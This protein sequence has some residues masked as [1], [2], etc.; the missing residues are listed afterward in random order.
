[1]FSFTSIFDYQEALKE[2]SLSCRDTVLYYIDRIKRL[3]HLNAF[4]QVYEK[5]ALT[6]ADRLDTERLEGK[7]TGRL[8]GVVIG[9]KDVI[10]IRDH[11]V[12]AGSHI[13]N[14]FHSVYHATAI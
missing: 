13:L 10:C 7:M 9:I 3:S 8:H 2:G 14:G 12:S 1:L 6:N 11:P 4:V 5:E